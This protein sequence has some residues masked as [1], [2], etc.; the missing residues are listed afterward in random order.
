MTLLA[1]DT[2]ALRGDIADDIRTAIQARRDVLVALNQEIGHDP[3]LAF[4]EHRAAAR[5]ATLLEREGFA[6]TRAAYG[7]DTAVEAVYGD[8]E[9][10]VAVVGEYDALPGVGHAC[11]HNI[12]ATAGVGAAIGLKSVADRLGLRVKFLATPAEELGGGKALMLQAGAWDD[13]T[14]SLMVHGGPFR[15]FASV[16]T[17]TQA[18][19]RLSATFEGRAAHA[20]AAPH[21]GINAGDAVTLSQVGLGLLRQQLRRGVVVGSYVVESGRATN[22]IAERGVLEVEVRGN[23]SEEWN[24]A[25]RRVRDVLAGAALATG[26]RV[27]VAQPEL[28]YDALRPD[29]DLS[30]LFDAVVV[31]LGYEIEPAPAGI[32][33]GSTDMGNVSQYLPSAHP[34]ISLRGVEAVPHHQSFA[35][36]AVSPAGDEAAINGALALALSAAAAVQDDA[37]RERL[38]AEQRVRPPYADFAAAREAA[39]DPSGV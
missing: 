34:M 36:A 10:T 21:E 19:E 28:P 35:A 11:G 8:G 14:F 13:A 5:V 2:T 9:V 27:E 6:V 16:G 24:D 3:E 37:V 12:I 32:G 33:G 30:R 39:A 15:Q 26:C 31:S 18:Y 22:V 20:A 7:L 4:E 29:D 23:T 25:R 17:V 1:D 38:L